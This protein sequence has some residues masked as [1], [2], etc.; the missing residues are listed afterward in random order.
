MGRQEHF[1]AFCFCREREREREIICVLCLI[2]AVHPSNNYLKMQP[3]INMTWNASLHPA[4]A[5]APSTTFMR[6]EDWRLENEDWRIQGVLVWVFPRGRKFIPGWKWCQHWGS[7]PARVKLL[8]MEVFD[9]SQLSSGLRGWLWDEWD[10]EQGAK[11]SS[12]PQKWL[13]SLH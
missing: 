9:T 10:I 1:M 3:N 12:Q 5:H 4:A 6:M 2:V 11:T 13:H 8:T 7:H